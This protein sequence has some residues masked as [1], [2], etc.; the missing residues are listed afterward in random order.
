L[1]DL[2]YIGSRGGAAALRNFD[3]IIIADIDCGNL[4][5]KKSS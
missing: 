1:F 5:S 4:Y 2:G 3:E